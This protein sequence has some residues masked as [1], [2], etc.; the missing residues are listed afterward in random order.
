MQTNTAL[1][2]NPINTL[3]H[4]HACGSPFEAWLSTSLRITGLRSAVRRRSSLFQTNTADIWR[5]LSAQNRTFILS[6]ALHR[7]ACMELCAARREAL[8]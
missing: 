4:N 7:S 8:H 5:M 1:F 3:P 6:E 2:T